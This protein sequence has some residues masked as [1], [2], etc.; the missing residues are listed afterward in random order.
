MFAS[1]IST[2]LHH[3]SHV[4]AVGAL[5]CAALGGSAR[6]GIAEVGAMRLDYADTWQRAGAA[7]EDEDDSIILRHA[8]GPEDMTV[9]L[10]RR[11]V[12]LKIGEAQFYDQLERKWRAQYGKAAS[13]SSIDANGRSWRLCV[14]PSLERP[15]TVFHLVTVQT[16]RAHHL[17]AV[18]KRIGS[19]LPKELQ[20]L[21]GGVAWPGA[22][23]LIVAAAPEAP[24]AP[25]KVETP[26]PSDA[27]ATHSGQP[28]PRRIASWQLLR[29]SRQAASGQALAELA[30]LEIRRIGDSGMLLGYGLTTREHG[31]DWFIDGYQFD[32]YVPGRAGRK[33][34]A[35]NWGLAWKAPATWDGG[36]VL[37]IPV[38]FIGSVMPPDA[39]AQAGV[40]AEL[41]LLCGPRMAVVN[42][43][44]AIDRGEPGAAGQLTALA[45]ACPE[46]GAAGNGA[47][48]LVSSTADSRSAELRF[49]RLLSLP[50]SLTTVAALPEGQARRILLTLRGIASAQGD[51]LGDSL[52]SGATAYYVY[53]PAS[54]KQP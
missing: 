7:E 44:D 53:G 17:L 37:R 35:L 18:G 4:L 29:A 26:S 28:V 21:L 11:V 43:M 49:E 23:P 27:S 34:Y 24:A 48:L 41:R 45:Q 40:R 15:A 19:G 47:E 52:L 38:S 31:L 51:A 36:P 8:A 32:P 5:L 50:N 14:R 20:T 9:F 25:A 16:G 22:E 3:V 42:A 33:A 2:K 30:D 54:L 1:D 6:A 10:P 13:I 39:V 12:P 46:D